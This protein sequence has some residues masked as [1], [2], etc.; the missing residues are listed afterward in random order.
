MSS[1]N[2][3]DGYPS[4]GNRWLLTDVL[5]NEW[6]FKGAVVS[7]WE[8]ITEMV[9]HRFCA[10]NKEAALRAITAGVD[11]DM[12]SNAYTDYLPEL[13]KEGKVSMTTVDDAV[14]NV[15]RLKHTLGLFENPYCDTTLTGVYGAPEHLALAQRAAEE[16]IV[17][18]K[19][20]NNIL[21]YN[22]S[23]KK[24]LLV[25]PLADAPAEQLG[26][27]AMDGDSHLSVTPL[28]ALQNV[29]GK[30]NV[31]Y[32]QG[33]DSSRDTSTV[34]FKEIK[35]AAETVDI[36]IAMVGEEAIL[37][38]E[39][40]CLTNLNL[41]GKQSALIHMLSQVGKPLVTIV[42]AGR[43]LDIANDMDASDALLY[44]FAPGTMG[45][46]AIINTI[47]G[48]NN[49]SAKLPVTFPQNVG[50]IPIY[51]NHNNTGRPADGHEIYIADIPKGAEQ[52]ALGNKSYYLDANGPLFSFGDGLS[53][54]TYRYSNLA[55]DKEKFHLS[56]S[57]TV[58]FDIDNVGKFDGTE[59]LQVYISDLAAT[60]VR[61]ILELV[62]FD[63]VFLKSGESK[64]YQFNLPISALSYW[65]GNS[66]GVEP[67]RFDL[68]VG[69]NTH[70]L[71]KKSFEVTE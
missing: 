41:Q 51:Y 38:G 58:S 39:A 69:G 70:Q 71:L 12:V 17:L 16:S 64:H 1:F 61:P 65:D 7:D 37:S 44:C 55:I 3:N 34:K 59:I 68:F 9:A 50:Q 47:S 4:S 52:T 20:D 25:G 36:I 43:P 57:I 26:T 8:A 35:H 14:R 31:T 30:K 21:P 49:P 60:I 42:M 29:I 27:W 22:L 19:N 62:H 15:L 11:I 54:T 67:G 23:G 48:V 24:V 53:Y 10:D 63:R 13:I 6:G 28:K 66:W 33:L 56:D 40:H 2:D 5:R 18:L 45:G 32:I 46:P